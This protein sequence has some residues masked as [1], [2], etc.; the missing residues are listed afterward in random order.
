MGTPHIINDFPYVTF[1]ADEQ[2][3]LKSLEG[4]KVDNLHNQLMP[5]KPHFVDNLHLTVQAWQNH[6]NHNV[7]PIMDM[8]DKSTI[9]EKSEMSNESDMWVNRYFLAQ[10]GEVWIVWHITDIPARAD[11]PDYAH[12]VRKSLETGNS[13][14]F[15]ASDGMLTM[16]TA[17]LFLTK[18]QAN[19]HIN[20]SIRL[21]AHSDEILN[22]IYYLNDV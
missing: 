14:G 12:I 9:A 20:E 22:H 7:E 3:A 13:W 19:Q 15:V 4:E 17:A 10:Q 18:I 11:D 8:R 2:E 21:T 1:T 6:P 5:G 16:A